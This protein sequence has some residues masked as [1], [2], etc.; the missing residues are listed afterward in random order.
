MGKGMGKGLGWGSN[1]FL[2]RSGPKNLL[3]LVSGE[4]TMI[5]Q[6][7]DKHVAKTV[8]TLPSFQGESRIAKIPMRFI[9]FHIHGEC[10]PTIATKHTFA[11][12]LISSPRG[13]YDFGAQ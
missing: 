12:G 3:K 10:D 4:T 2:G 13:M 8:R 5:K 9:I 11:K 6:I 1:R 7:S